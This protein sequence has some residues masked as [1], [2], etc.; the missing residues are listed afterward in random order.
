MRV[1]ITG[2]SGFLGSHV[3]D[4]L[5]DAGH[6]VVVFDNRVSPYLR[7]GQEMITG[8]VLDDPET[9]SKAMAGCEAVYHFAAIS[10][11]GEAMNKPYDTV[12]TNAL[13]TANLIEAARIA[14]ISRFVFA[15]SIYVYSS[16]G[17]V[18]RTSK[19][20]CEG[21]LENYSEL[22]GMA[23]TIL[24]YGSL[25]GPR[26]DERNSVHRMLKQALVD[27][28]I[29]YPGTGEEVREYIHVLDAAR[30]SV[31]VLDDA[32]ANQIMHLTGRERMTVSEVLTMMREILSNKVEVRYRNEQIEGHYFQTPYTYTPKLGKRMTQ[33]TY[34][35]LGLGL[36]DCVQDIDHTISANADT[37]GNDKESH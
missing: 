2:G 9:L 28:W 7:P 33:P 36:L 4:A 1:L 30:M 6:D 11:I 18:Y 32:Y 19:Q 17:S 21:L 29:E 12:Q 5:S 10:D 35:D 22:Y 27:G 24:R 13:G 20:F 23:Y 3:A 8:S 31:E 16:Q 37:S 34:I 14:G 25:Y 15:S 26:A